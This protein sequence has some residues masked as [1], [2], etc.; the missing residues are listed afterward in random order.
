MSSPQSNNTRS[1]IFATTILLDG[2]LPTLGFS[3]GKVEKEVEPPRM[4]VRRSSLL[5]FRDDGDGGEEVQVPPPVEVAE[6]AQEYMSTVS[7]TLEQ[8]QDA[9]SRLTLPQWGDATTKYRRYTSEAL[10][11]RQNQLSAIM[12]DVYSSRDA[13]PFNYT[14]HPKLEEFLH[15]GGQL[16][17]PDDIAMD[18]KEYLK[19]SQRAVK[20]ARGFDELCE[21]SP[22][23][24]KIAFTTELNRPLQLV[25]A[26]SLLSPD[27]ESGG[28]S[29]I[30]WSL[31]H[32]EVSI[33]CRV[34]DDSPQWVMRNEGAQ[35]AYGDSVKAD[36]EASEHDIKSLT[37]SPETTADDF[38]EYTQRYENS[39][40]V[41]AAY[42]TAKRLTYVDDGECTDEGMLREQMET[43][44][45]DTADVRLV[46]GH[47]VKAAWLNP[48]M[49]AVVT[50]QLPRERGFYT[51]R[52][53]EYKNSIKEGLAVMQSELDQQERRA[54]T[55]DVGSSAATT[56]GTWSM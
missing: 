5:S 51:S 25:R 47:L 53:E 26:P 15:D 8:E 29:L 48:C 11:A 19:R 2:C 35:K 46:D 27:G 14:L 17:G 54:E 22:D 24:V 16:V 44:G 55:A 12:S 45:E 6:A 21:A 38:A 20:S 50:G 23:T 37:L 42:L 1:T 10:T 28:R 36:I 52:H 49:Y 18:H 4:E 3:R 34:T 56:W 40:F 41:K 31:S 7:L 39:V 30:G 43:D 33:G 9:L 13:W 32:P